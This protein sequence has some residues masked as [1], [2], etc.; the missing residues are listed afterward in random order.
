MT[1]ASNLP[2]VHDYS[3]QSLIKLDFL[4]HGQFIFYGST[5]TIWGQVVDIVESI[6]G[7]AFQQPVPSHPFL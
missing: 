4:F 5:L 7:V 3:N 6:L 1:C 2:P